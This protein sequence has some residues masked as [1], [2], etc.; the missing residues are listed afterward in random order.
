MSS[1]LD[2]YFD[3]NIMSVHLIQ[4]EYP[5]AKYGSPGNWVLKKISDKKITEEE[6]KNIYNTLIIEAQQ[7]KNSF[8]EIQRN[9]SFVL[10]INNYRVVIVH[11]PVS[12]KYEITIVKP[13]VSLD[14]TSYDLPNEILNDI[15]NQSEG[16]LIAGAPGNGKSTF[17]ASIANYLHNKLK[18]VKTVESPRDLQVVDGIVQ[19]SNIRASM[20][21]IRDILLLSRPDYTFY[22]EIR[23]KDDFLLFKDLRLTGIGMVGVIH[24]TKPIDAL[25][26][27]IGYVELGILPQIITK[28]LF[29]K[30]GNISNIYTLQYVVKVPYGMTEADL[31]RPVVIVKENSSIKFEIY[32]FGEEV[33]VMPIDKQ[34]VNNDESPIFK[35]AKKEIEKKLDKE[36]KG[37]YYDFDII[38]PYKIILYIDDKFKGRVIGQ[39]GSN[40]SKLENKIGI[41]IE[42]Q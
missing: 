22:D 7:L 24:A 2:K 12:D 31:A 28:I 35:L 40:I 11:P 10:Q 23:N 19:Y 38:S 36:L 33:V 13:I 14:I 17:A 1:I 20:S 16:I 3:N 34:N 4:D 15:E 26:R 30:N 6:I 21:E 42:V 27:F 8:V 29:I 9:S 39:K 37:I 18:I 32:T 25:Q 41:S 5:V